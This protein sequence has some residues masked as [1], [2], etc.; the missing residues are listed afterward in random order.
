LTIIFAYGILSPVCPS[1]IL[2][3]ILWLKT[4]C[5]RKANRKNRSEAIFGRCFVID[6]VYYFLNSSAIKKIITAINII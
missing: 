4:C 6:K 3:V 2:A 1:M 5:G